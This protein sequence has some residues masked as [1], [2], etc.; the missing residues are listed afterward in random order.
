MGKY[1]FDVLV[2]G[3]GS[4]GLT[5]AKLASGLGKKTAMADRE[6]LG[7][8]CTWTGCIPSKALLKSSAAYRSLFYMDKLGIKPGL[9]KKDFKT[10]EIFKKVQDIRE[11]VY[12]SHPPAAFEES[13]IKV[14]EHKH[15]EFIDSHNVR[16]GEKEYSADKIIIATGSSPSIPTIPGLSGVEYRT[17]QNVFDLK[18]IPASIIII[19]G[20]AIGAE[21]A[22]AFAQLG[23]DVTIL[24]AEGHILPREDREVSSFITEEMKSLGIKIYTGI[25]IKE[26]SGK[27]AKKV[28]IEEDGEKKTL[29]AAEIFVAAGRKPNIE[30]LSLELAGVHYS[31]RGITTDLYLQTSTKNIYACGDVAGPYQFSH[32][33]GYQAKVA[34]SNALLPFKKKADYSNV[35]WITF[36]SPECARSGLTETE[37]RDIYGTGIKIFR[38]E[39][40]H[41]DRSITDRNL[42]G[43]AKVITRRNGEIIGIH[44]CGERAGEVMHEL[45]LA[46][47]MRIPLYRLQKVIHAYP[48]YS[49]LIKDLSKDAYIDKLMSNPIVKFISFLRGKK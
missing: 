37:A 46:K 13:G 20:G 22:T 3:E 45:H 38:K 5:A 17:N 23:S 12:N 43:F 29:S 30:G 36:T 8:E 44:I 42:K 10:G 28:I 4:A 35:P 14:F 39:Y 33:A 34:V 6:K 1:D 15:V 32:M 48:S 9:K 47:T 2:I 19:G 24:E 21:M 25:S 49:D 7:G 27:A 40:E 26:V 31:T 41:L 18:Q 16:I 11:N